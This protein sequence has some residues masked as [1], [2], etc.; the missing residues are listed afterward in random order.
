MVVTPTGI[1]IELRRVARSGTHHL[2]FHNVALSGTHQYRKYAVLCRV[3][4]LTMVTPN[5]A[6][7]NESGSYAV[8]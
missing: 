1:K 2:E 8:L 4:L 3:V 6:Q 5:C 7:W